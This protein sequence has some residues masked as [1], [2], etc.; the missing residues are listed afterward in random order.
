MFILKHV[1]NCKNVSD[2]EYQLQNFLLYY[3]VTKHCTTDVSPAQ[4]MF[5]REIRTRL[6]LVIPDDLTNEHVNIRSNIK[7]KHEKQAKY[8]RGVRCIKFL[9][10]QS[11][12]VKDFRFVKPRWTPAIIVKSLDIN[13]YKVKVPD[14]D[15]IWKR[16]VN[17][18]LDNSYTDVSCNVRNVSR[19]RNSSPNLINNRFSQLP[20][21]EEGKS[22]FKDDSIE[23]I[24]LT[25][26]SSSN[27]GTPQRPIRN[28]KPPNRL[29]YD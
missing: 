1:N 6:S 18:I 25:S 16:H 11:V 23:V 26:P 19:S 13:V 5:G 24:D 29:V 12:L 7:R 14:T 22:S 20:L 9:P 8:Y 27:G 4:A 15:I 17:Q 3:R 21:K 28:R 10:G 2:L